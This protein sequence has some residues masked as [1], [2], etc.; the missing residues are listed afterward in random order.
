MTFMRKLLDVL[1]LDST[2][3][4]EK[5]GDEINNDD[6]RGIETVYNDR[7][8]EEHRPT[9]RK[10]VVFIG[11]DL[12]EPAVEACA[13]LI[14]S[15]SVKRGEKIKPNDYYSYFERLYGVVNIRELHIWLYE[16]DYLRKATPKEALNLYKVPE[17]KAILDSMGLKKNG[18][19]Q[20]LIDRIV[21]NLDSAMKEKLSNECDRY[22]RSEKGEAF[23]SENQDYV[24]FHRKQYGV[25]FQEFCAHRLLQGKKREF[26]DTIFHV[27]SQKA[28]TYQIKGYI[29]QL[30][31][32]YHDLSDCLY[33]D[34]KYELSLQNAL[35]S[36]Y[37]STN[38]ASKY[39]LFSIGNVR[40]DG[41]EKAKSRID[42]E[43]TFN[44][45]I[46]GRILELQPYFRE[47]MLD[48]VY[49]PEILPYC[50]FRKYDMLD[51]VLDL[52]DNAFDPEQYANY[53]RI[54]YEKYIKKFI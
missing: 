25:T 40:F 10:T 20:D 19:K 36:L 11:Y 54:N 35:Y 28:Y 37:F 23:L 17:L 21:E 18:N 12:S 16:H 53:I 9:F 49:T 45:H 51:V 42:S 15:G 46:I 47:P 31:M 48:V 4:T 27:L 1:K 5:N 26:Y 44:P 43:E 3:E 41:I 22:F 8:Y 30:E 7:F 39:H 2:R 32:I 14:I 52:Y 6:K 24:L 33:D 13:A 38:L 34:Q 29:S 50:L